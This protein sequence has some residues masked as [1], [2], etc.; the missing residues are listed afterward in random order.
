M[1]GQAI[2]KHRRERGMTQDFLAMVIGVSRQAMQFY[3][4][5]RREPPMETLIRIAHA[6]DRPVSALV[7][8]LDGLVVPAREV[9]R[10]DGRIVL[11]VG[12]QGEAGERDG[13]SE[14][15]PLAG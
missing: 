3:E 14:R 15:P 5:G 13:G 11:G 6:V 10:R 8:E 7:A 4:Q 12:D 2:A 9:R 1:L